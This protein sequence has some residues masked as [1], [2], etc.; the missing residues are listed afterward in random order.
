MKLINTIELN[1]ETRKIYFNAVSG[2]SAKQLNKCVGAE[3][4]LMDVIMQEQEELDEEGNHKV[5][6]CLLTPE[7]EVYQTLSPTV[8]KSVL[9]IAQYYN[10]SQDQ[11]SVR[12]VTGESKSGREFLQLYII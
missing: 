10:I 7:G 12:V 4:K 8:Y 5:L 2:V 9:N 3:I 11:P 1:D 6:T